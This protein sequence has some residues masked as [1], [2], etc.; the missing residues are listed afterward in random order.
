MKKTIKKMKKFIINNKANCL[1][2]FIS[3]LAFIIGGLA[4]NWLLAFIIVA[5]IDALL[6]GLPNILSKFK[7]T[8]KKA[9]VK[10][11][12]IASKMPDTPKTKTKVKSDKKG[13][14]KRKKKWWKV[15]LILF[16]CF[17]ILVLI[18]LI[19]FFAIIVKNAPNFDPN[20][21]YQK[22]A[23]ILYDNSGKEFQKLGAQHRETISYED[24]PEVLIN[25]IIATEDSRFFQHNG[26]DLPRFLKAAIGQVAGN[27]SAGGASTITMQVVKNTYTSTEDEGIKGIM[28]KFTDIY[29]SIFKLEK[30][31]TKKEILEFY[32]NSYYMGG[33]AW[34]VEQA[35]INYFG[36]H[37]KDLTLPEASL[38]AGLFQS[39]NTYNPFYN[40][41]K[42]TK[43]RSTVLK[44]MERHG[45]IT[46]E[47][48][49]AAEAVSIESLLTT[50]TTEE[51]K[52][53]GFI[54]VVV[55]EVKEKT[56]HNPYTTPMKIYTTMDRSK[57]DYI[58]SIMDGTIWNWENDNVQAGISVINTQTG[59][60]VAV[61]AN[62]NSNSDNRIDFATS[63]KRQIGSTAKPLYDYG[64][65]IEYNNWSTYSLL[66]DE[67]YQYS[68][69]QQI[70]NWDGGYQGLITARTALAG[71]RNIP[72][73]K[74]FQQVS[75]KN[76]KT[77]VTNL[78]LS[79]EIDSN[80][81]HEAHSIGGYNGESPLTM[82][83]AYA[84]FANG[85]YYNEPRSYTKIIYRETGKEVENKQNKTR[86]MSD[87]TAYMVNDMLITTSTQALG[88]YANVNGL[89]FAAKTG[90][91]NFTEA[92]KQSKGLPD[93]A[94]NDYWVVG[95]TDEY[96]IGVWY[97][98]NKVSS[99]TYNTFGTMYH[100]S[101]F[102]T[103][104]KGMFSRSTSVKKPD[105]VLEVTV[106]KDTNPAKLPSAYTP[107]DMKITELFRK[108]AEP[109]EVSTRFS[110]LS[111]PTN[112]STSYSSGKVKITWSKIKTPDALDD[113]K[114]TELAKLSFTT[115]GYQQAY[116]SSIKGYNSS[117]LGSLGY[118]IYIKDS[119][120]TLTYVGSSTG[121]NYSYSVRSTATPIT[122]VVK[123]AYSNFK[124]NAST[125]VETTIKFSGSDSI[126][127]ANLNGDATVSKNVGEIYSDEGVTV[128]DNLI[129]VTSQASINITVKDETGRNIGSRVSSIDFTTAG[130]Y[131]VT[132][133]V[134]YRSLS[135]TLTRTIIIT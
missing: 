19:I 103:V 111:N 90:T 87:E 78:G 2:A 73:L 112:V 41:E 106:E 85:G 66:G 96:S 10:P 15:L 60:I 13:K 6:F 26:F 72:A 47:E 7:K 40:L 44:L 129:D 131:T 25:A 81:V 30:K 99:T 95:M 35:S 115:A 8:G 39:P 69:G 82:S 74:T 17:C 61:G 27:S 86:A 29:M 100:A 68:T 80:M 117:V 18:A 71:S 97:G 109:T 126:T 24:L 118:D 93:N 11:K 37:A 43:R 88:Y 130:K 113:A 79:P 12:T 38:I 3:L 36:K 42:A 91:S 75:N 50:K 51:V 64:P 83:A 108:G 123:A 48:R 119:N 124:S 20:E 34:G 14:P 128:Y 98:Y 59:E 110:Q 62:R 55:D 125:G 53:Q 21:L 132:Y 89:T 105:G 134:S 45:Y 114:I 58:N 84:A 49:K 133:K 31:Y 102:N 121:E 57:Q 101:M 63:S 23:T 52:Y 9:K 76:I 70:Y 104:A 116:I 122:F 32:V 94:I 65:A 22:E 16:F 127:T 33:G 56:G 67:P 28:R 54:D 120:G 107:D 1:L 135:E 5:V 92:D 4:T 46:S 77:F